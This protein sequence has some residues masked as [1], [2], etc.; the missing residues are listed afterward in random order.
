[1]AAI[2]ESVETLD[3]ECGG[4]AAQAV[5][6]LHQIVVYRD[7]RSRAGEGQTESPSTLNEVETC[8]CEY[9][10]AL[11]YGVEFGARRARK[12]LQLLPRSWSQRPSADPAPLMLSEQSEAGGFQPAL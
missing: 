12:R 5:G 10:G 6:S 7:H 8:A 11:R 1:M 2:H 9:V 4:A 3:A